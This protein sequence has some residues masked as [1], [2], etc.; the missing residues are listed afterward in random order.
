MF[1]QTL[2]HVYMAATG[3]PECAEVKA[4]CRNRMPVRWGVVKVFEGARLAMIPVSG[5]LSEQ[6]DEINSAGT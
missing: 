3:W 5:S 6:R 2:W 4:R 1:D